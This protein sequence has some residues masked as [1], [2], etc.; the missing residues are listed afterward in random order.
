MTHWRRIR[1]ED[2]EQYLAMVDAFYRTDGVIRPIPRAHSE[3]CFNELMRSKQYT[4]AYICEAGGET[5]GYAL[6]AR[7][8]SQEAGGIV[9]WVEELFIKEAHRGKGLGKAFFEHLLDTLPDDVRRVRLEIERDNARAIAVYK[10][11]GFDFFEYDQMI[12]ER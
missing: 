7:T 10:H 8:F 11:F 3:A 6:L 5:V 1:P 2:R 12:L 4:Y 9:L